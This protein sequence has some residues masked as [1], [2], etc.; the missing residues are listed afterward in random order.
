VKH[1][2]RALAFFACLSAGASSALAFAPYNLALLPLLGLGV[3]FFCWSRA[4][5]PWQGF[6]YGFAFGLGLFGVGTSW[7]FYSIQQFGESTAAFATF[8]TGLFVVIFAATSGLAGFL[9]TLW[10]QPKTSFFFMRWRGFQLLLLFPACWVLGEYSRHWLFFPWLHLG[11]SQ[12]D[13]LLQGYAPLVG[14]YGLSF[15]LAQAAGSLVFFFLCQKVFS[16]F[17]ILLSLVLLWSMGGFLS[18]IEWSRPV[19]PKLSVSLLQGNMEQWRQGEPGQ[20]EAAFRRYQRLSERQW[21]QDLLVWPETAI[22]AFVSEVG[23]ELLRLQQAAL[24]KG[25]D[26]ILGI[27]ANDDAGRFYNS[28]LLLGREPSLYHKQRLV[29]FGEYIPWRPLLAPLARW[30][31]IPEGDLAPAS[32]QN[33]TFFVHE[34]AVRI[35]ICYEVAFADHW[36]HDSAFLVNISNDGW[37]GTTAAPKQH[38]QIARMRALENS[39]Y[40]LR[41]T[42]SGI[43]AIIDEKGK[44]ISSLMPFTVGILQGEVLARQG[45]TPFNHWGDAPLFG[46]FLLI[47][48]LA[49]FGHF[50]YGQHLSTAST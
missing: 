25:S 28:A 12:L 50:S 32:A 24:A 40:L 19:G 33:P 46:I 2:Y 18:T 20:L 23:D 11:D 34:Q 37:F 1:L 42:N 22:P 15:L 43:T 13:T 35:G 4:T 29:P 48:L 27:F 49:F 17:L 44:I 31:A 36:R 30:V 3:L 5:T 21:G 39:R 10:R 6:G 7:I 14:S 38:L 9:A 16:K 8:L 45:K 41:A 26:V 47:F